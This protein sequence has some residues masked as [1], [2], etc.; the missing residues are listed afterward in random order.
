[1]KQD[2]Y[3][4]FTN[5]G[6]DQFEKFLPQTLR[7]GYLI[8]ND[9]LWVP[10]GAI[11]VEKCVGAAHSVTLR[12]PSMVFTKSQMEASEIMRECYPRILAGMLL[13]LLRFLISVIFFPCFMIIRQ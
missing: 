12:A 2:A 11:I 13:N 6:I 5:V 7:W 3:T 4:Y 9:V 10:F 8:P 1:M